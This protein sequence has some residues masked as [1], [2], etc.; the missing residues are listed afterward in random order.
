MGSKPPWVT[1]L[2]GVEA[3]EKGAPTRKSSMT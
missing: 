3:F 2:A 1:P